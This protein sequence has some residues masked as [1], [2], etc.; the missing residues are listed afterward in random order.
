MRI[1]PATELLQR[2]HALQS[3]L[4]E[5]GLD[6]ALL[7]QNA[8][9][10]YFTGSI[11]QGMFFLPSRGPAVYLVRK[12]IRR[13]RMESGLEHVLPL[14]SMGEVPQALA[15]LGINDFG[16]IGLELDV[17]P[18]LQYRR[19]AKMFPQAELLD[20]SPLVRQVRAIKS[21]YE[22]GVM[23]DAALMM[24]RI[25]RHA[26]EVIKVGRS[27]L[28]VAA[29]LE[30]FART[31]GHQGVI[32]FRAFN[33]EIFYGHLFSGADAAAPAYLDAPLGGL[34]VN[35]SVGQGASYKTIR[36]GE[37]IILDYIAAFDGY[38]AD[39]T[40]TLVIGELPDQLSKA[41]YDMLKIQEKLFALARPG[42]SWGEI[43][44]QCH[45]LAMDLGYRDHFMGSAGA[46]VSFIGHGIGLEVDEYP[47]IARGYDDRLLEE[48]MTFAFEPK[49]VY[50]GLG[51]VGVE[52]TWRV[53][54]EG[55]KRLT[56]SDESLISL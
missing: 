36:A 55:I 33:A 31:Q 20:V 17:L 9:L 37:P 38:L 40:R 23:K 42:V 53:G 34:G 56:F 27:D 5:S 8:D 18:V 12:D 35:P 48:N 32:R 45:Q 6:G 19:L 46:Q 11:Q 15:G 28:E 26:L 43:Y 47:F 13:A 10:F 21:D 41:Y 29:D 3:Q 24:D 39:Q 7:L 1:T 22:I 51:A 30:H 49:A 25:Y 16:R 14:T 54:K 44:R 4:Q 52:N 50:P 2:S